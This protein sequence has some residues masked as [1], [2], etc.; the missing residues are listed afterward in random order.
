MN[1]EVFL[2]HEGHLQGR[3]LRLAP[4]GRAVIA[5]AHG[6]RQPRG[7]YPRPGLGRGPDVLLRVTGLDLEV[8]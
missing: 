8:V 6:Q 1:G 5:L 7:R 4:D 3:V 2:L